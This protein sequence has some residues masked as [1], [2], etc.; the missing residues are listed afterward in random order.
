LWHIC[1][2]PSTCLRP[3][4]ASPSKLAIQSLQTAAVNCS[5]GARSTASGAASLP[6][7]SNILRSTCPRRESEANAYR[8]LAWLW[9]ATV[10]NRSHRCNQMSSAPARWRTARCDRR[11]PAQRQSCPRSASSRTYRALGARSIKGKPALIYASQISGAKP[12]PNFGWLG[13]CQMS[14]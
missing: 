4:A 8:A 3:S 11:A 10:R 7:A 12:R 5:A 13:V 14:R 1:G 2:V 9:Q 6:P